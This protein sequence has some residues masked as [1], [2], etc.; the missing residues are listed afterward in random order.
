MTCSLKFDR[1]CR[2][3]STR[4]PSE[5]PYGQHCQ[6]EVGDLER[7]RW[8]ESQPAI[9]AFFRQFRP[10]LPLFRQIPAL[11]VRCNFTSNWPQIALLECG[12]ADVLTQ[13]VEQSWICHKAAKENDLPIF[14]DGSMLA[15]QRGS[16]KQ[17]KH[18]FQ[19]RA[20]ARAEPTLG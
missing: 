7:E 20:P 10:L 1:C 11:F 3:V 19:A 8:R 5:S 12:A 2:L 4:A 6:L 14:V 9:S 18:G 17:C 13:F 16:H 15:I